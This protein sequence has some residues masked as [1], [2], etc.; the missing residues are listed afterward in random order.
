MLILLL[1]ENRTDNREPV[2]LKLSQLLLKFLGIKNRH[3]SIK[4]RM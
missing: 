4:W 3:W 2:K 1:K